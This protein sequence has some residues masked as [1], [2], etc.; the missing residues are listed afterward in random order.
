[1]STS[2]RRAYNIHGIDNLMLTVG[3]YVVI[4]FMNVNE[5]NGIEKVGKI[6]N[7][8]DDETFEIIL[9]NSIDINCYKVTLGKY[10]DTTNNYLF[11]NRFVIINYDD[12]VAI[13]KPSN[14]LNTY[15]ISES[16]IQVNDI[17]SILVSKNKEITNATVQVTHIIPDIPGSYT[18]IYKYMGSIEENDDNI[19]MY[20]GTIEVCET[21]GIRSVVKLIAYPKYNQISL[22]SANLQQLLKVHFEKFV[23]RKPA[24]IIPDLKEAT[25]SMTLVIRHTTFA[26]NFYDT[27]LIPNN[28][29]PTIP[30]YAKYCGRTDTKPIRTTNDPYENTAIGFHSNN[31]G[32]FGFASYSAELLNLKAKSDDLMLTLPP[33]KD[34]L[35]IGI[36]K[37]NAKGLLEYVRWSTVSPQFLL[38]FTLIMYNRDNPT[39]KNI[40]QN[41]LNNK[42]RLINLTDVLS[43][44]N[45]P[46]DY[47]IQQ[48]FRTIPYYNSADTKLSSNFYIEFYRIISTYSMAEYQAL[49][50]EALADAKLNEYPSKVEYHIALIIKNIIWYV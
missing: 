8:K 5:I 29:K 20:R 25:G 24:T 39:T 38:F 11:I 14:K 44:P 31:I 26:P 15:G 16:D 1:M 10:T 4:K 7:I 13:C 43:D 30:I 32:V 9:N 48:S 27:K 19:N 40:G 21:I 42:L 2:I 36:V 23:I 34:S 45:K 46:D 6:S 35:I 3:T 49:L 28:H 33:N 18:F 41:E 47:K 12:I 50:E 22:S 17:L 37:K